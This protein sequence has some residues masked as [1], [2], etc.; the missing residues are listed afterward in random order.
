MFVF[1][2]HVN[3]GGEGRVMSFALYQEEEGQGSMWGS[4]PNLKRLS[5]K[6]VYSSFEHSLRGGLNSALYYLCWSSGNADNIVAKLTPHT[7][8]DSKVYGLNKPVPLYTS[9]MQFSGLLVLYDSILFILSKR[10]SLLSVR[11]QIPHSAW[12]DLYGHE[13][14]VLCKMITGKLS[15]PFISSSVKESYILLNWTDNCGCVI[16]QRLLCCFITVWHHQML[17][18]KY[19][20]P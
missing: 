20:I 16:S 11:D 2:E 9:I 14:G 10:K 6:C 12:F 1:T 13:A 19:T 8:Y 18:T 7:D 17:S 15:L 3:F 5:F 4:C